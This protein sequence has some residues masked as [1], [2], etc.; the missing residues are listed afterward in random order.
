MKTNT[1]NSTKLKKSPQALR[2]PDDLLARV[3]AYAERL[4]AEIHVSVSRSDAIRRLLVLGLEDAEDIRE[5]E[6]SL[7]ES[8]GV[9]LA[10][11]RAEYDL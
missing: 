8:G 6:Q 10:T 7:L 11:A 1:G 5:A 3:D 4:E 2:L 9:T